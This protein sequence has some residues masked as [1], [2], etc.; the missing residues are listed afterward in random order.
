[1]KDQPYL[2]YVPG[3]DWEPDETFLVR[4][5][6]EAIDYLVRGRATT[7]VP[8]SK[9]VFRK[10]QAL[11]ATINTAEIRLRD[12]FK[13]IMDLDFWDTE[14]PLVY[15]PDYAFAKMWEEAHRMNRVFDVQKKWRGQEQDEPLAEWELE[16]L[17]Q[18]KK[19]SK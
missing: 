1:M 2:V 18:S 3:I 14:S 11:Q 12:L 8:V 6:Q 10:W 15:D 7:A 17:A 4:S 16:L 13:P 5:K 9:E 19:E